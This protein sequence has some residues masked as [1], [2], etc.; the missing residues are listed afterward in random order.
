MK[1]YVSR[2]V[3]GHYA[4]VP[5]LIAVAVRAGRP[6]ADRELQVAVGTIVVRDHRIAVGAGG[7]RRV[8]PHA[9]RRIHRNRDPI[10][11]LVTLATGAGRAI[12]ESE[13]QIQVR[14]IPIRDHRV[15]AAV[16][17]QRAVETDFARRVHGDRAPFS[18]LG[19]VS[20][21]AC[22]LLAHGELQVL[23]ADVVV[24]DQDIAAAVHLQRRVRA[25]VCG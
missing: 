19:A 1:A 5:R 17:R 10:R 21:R 11:R 8:L 16:H 7:N 4:P 23:V 12:A 3:R 14:H 13:L 2:R 15:A 24:R 20:V 9:S 18:R 25:G 6:V 22:R